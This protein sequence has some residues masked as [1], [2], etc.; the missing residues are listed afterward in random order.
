[1][2]LQSTEQSP[3]RSI[4]DIRAELVRRRTELAASVPGEGRSVVIDGAGLSLGR[5]NARILDDLLRSLFQGLASGAIPPDP[6]RPVPASAW[7]E[8]ALA[9]VGSYGRGAVALKSDLD[10]RILVPRDAARTEALAE[11]LLYPLWDMGVAI[12]HQVVTIDD[13]VDAARDDLPTATSLL[14]FRWVTGDRGLV[15]ALRRRCDETVFA[16][17]EL[18]RFLGRLEQEVAQRHGR[19][20]GSVY[21][22][23]PDVK[24][25]EGGLRDLDVARWAVKA[26]FGVGEPEEL[27]RVGALVP[28]EATEILDAAERLWRIRNL[29][30]AHANRRSDR[31]TFDEQEAIAEVLGYGQNGEAVERLMSAYYRA[32]RTISRSLE[33]SIA[34]ATPVLSRRKPRDE[35]LGQGV[36]LFDGSVTMS[37]EDA[38]RADPALALRLVR[39][40]LERGAELLPW[41]RDAIARACDDPAFSA[42]LRQ[43]PEASALFVELVSSRRESALRAGSVRRELHATGLLLAMIPEFSPVVGRVHHDTYHVYTVDVHSVA[44]ADRLAELIRGEH[45]GEFPV[46]CRVAAELARP[47]MLFFATLLHDVGKAIGGT[48]HSQRGADMARPI[49]A[50]L[51]FPPEDIEEACH[52]VR[53]HLVMYLVA[54]RRDIDDPLTVAEFAREVH[55]REGLRDLYL[56]TVADL[57][58]TS[59]TSMTSWKARMLDELYLATDASIAASESEGERRT[60]SGGAVDSADARWARAAKEVADATEAMPATSDEERAERLAFLQTYLGSMPERYVLANVPAAVA[61]HAELARRHQGKIVTVDLVPSRHPEAAEICVVAMDRPGLLAAITAALAASRLEVHAAQIHTRTIPPASP[62]EAAGVQAVDLFWVRDRG[63]GIEGVARSLPKLTRDIGAVLAGE[64]SAP[65]LARNRGG[66]AVRERS[67][68]RVKIQ[69]SIDDRASPRHTVIEILARDRPGLLFALSDALYQ[70]G[71]SIAV[72]KINTEGA[73][74]ADVFYVSDREGKI[75]PESARPTCTAPSSRCSSGSTPKARAEPRDQTRISLPARIRFRI[76][77]SHHARHRRGRD[78]SPCRRRVLSAAFRARA[79]LPD[80][81]LGARVTGRFSRAEQ[82]SQRSAPCA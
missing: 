1:M 31:L 5:R 44:A 36:R 21:L 10:V 49:L 58:T 73:R 18:P 17:S 38:L 15:D 50:R 60:P 55:G 46:A 77:P 33:M 47:R 40:A 82:R 66:G 43:S 26:R 25:G 28:R 14:D 71:L 79:S 7:S 37:G 3:P 24:N 42:A 67:S 68:P 8:V 64:V 6:E 52:L 62:G 19:F 72:A 56:L 29:L 20:G 63:D 59:P 76:H 2:S 4:Q 61:A 39:A 11:A 81:G 75:P 69:V 41:A 27:V 70:L 23:E 74:V 35:D 45:A 16:H 48:D 65:D 54:T 9:G 53:K 80:G 32:A 22:L 57:S 34:R 30:H 78:A 13:L 12:G 51:G